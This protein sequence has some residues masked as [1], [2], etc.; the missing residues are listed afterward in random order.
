[1]IQGLNPCLL[2]WQVASLPAS[3][4]L[5]FSLLL[6]SISHIPSL[7]LESNDDLMHSCYL[8]DTLWGLLARILISVYKGEICKMTFLLLLL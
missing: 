1:M 3:H 6:S 8:A 7:D 4:K 5:I 2:H